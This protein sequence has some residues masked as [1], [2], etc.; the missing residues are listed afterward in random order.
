MSGLESELADALADCPQVAL[1]MAAV[2]GNRA[3]RARR[4][5]Q[6]SLCHELVTLVRRKATPTGVLIVLEDADRATLD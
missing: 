2:T 6:A 5:P 3:V 1:L 4:A